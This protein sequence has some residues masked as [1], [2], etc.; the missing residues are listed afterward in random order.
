MPLACVLLSRAFIPELVS[1]IVANVADVLFVKCS[2]VVMDSYDIW[3]LS[4]LMLP[5]LFI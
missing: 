1:I 5:K 3:E 4:L 2:Y